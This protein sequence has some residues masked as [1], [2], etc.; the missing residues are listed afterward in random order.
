[1]YFNIEKSCPDYVT[2]SPIIIPSPI[3]IHNNIRKNISTFNCKYAFK[4]W[5]KYSKQFSDVKYATNKIRETY[6][7][8]Q[9]IFDTVYRHINTYSLEYVM[10]FGIT[11]ILYLKN[12]ERNYICYS[13]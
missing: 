6:R 11:F 3:V 13:N 9:S 4:R 5:R 2:T 10:L 12:Q 7:S 1:M 8:Q